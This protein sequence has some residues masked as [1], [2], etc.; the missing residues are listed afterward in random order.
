MGAAYATTRPNGPSTANWPTPPSSSRW[1]G[2]QAADPADALPAFHGD[3]ADERDLE[4]FALDV[5]ARQP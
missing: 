5:R 4:Q 3:L 1:P 2:C